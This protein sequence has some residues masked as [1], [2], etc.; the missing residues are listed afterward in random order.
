MKKALIHTILIMGMF[1][2]MITIMLLLFKVF[3]SCEIAYNN[4]FS[5][6]VDNNYTDMILR[7]LAISPIIFV[8]IYYIEKKED[9]V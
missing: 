7:G 9:S 8:L 5:G 3:P 6:N 1:G 2:V 4:F